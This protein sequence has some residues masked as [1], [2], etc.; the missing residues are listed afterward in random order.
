M[1]PKRRQDQEKTSKSQTLLRKSQPVDEPSDDNAS[2]SSEGLNFDSDGDESIIQGNLPPGA[3]EDVDG[4]GAAP[5]TGAPGPLPSPDDHSTK[6]A[7]AP[8]LER[9]PA[10]HGLSADSILEPTPATY[11]QLLDEMTSSLGSPHLVWAHNLSQ[12]EKSS[13]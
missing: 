8:P 9:V 6:A 11:S 3:A 4:T 10:S 13:N 12:R 1:P 7:N 5:L 2:Q